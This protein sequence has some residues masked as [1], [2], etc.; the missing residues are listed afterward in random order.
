MNNNTVI[1]LHTKQLTLN[2]NIKYD[3]IEIS[4]REKNTFYNK[5]IGVEIMNEDKK[6]HKSISEMNIKNDLY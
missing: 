4:K 6:T 2:K 1:Y 5:I 3:S